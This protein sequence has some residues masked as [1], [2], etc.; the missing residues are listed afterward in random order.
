MARELITQHLEKE[1][2]LEEKGKNITYGKMSKSKGL[3]G[4]PVIKTVNAS[5]PRAPLCGWKLK[6]PHLRSE[7]IYTNQWG[8]GSLPI[9]QFGRIGLTSDPILLEF[10]VAVGDVNL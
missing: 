5:V 9:C 6:S 2:D 10:H 7:D 1:K 8:G 4:R 3:V